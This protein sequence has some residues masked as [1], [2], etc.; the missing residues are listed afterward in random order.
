MDP[1]SQLEPAREQVLAAIGEVV[2]STRFI[3][4]PVVQE[5]EQTLAA[6][7]GAT[8]GVGVGNGTDALVIAL[9]ALG[10]EPG[11]EV[12]CPSFT[13]YATAEAV[14]GIGAVPVFADIDPGT[15][16]LNPQPAGPALPRPRK[17][18]LGSAS[19]APPSTPPPLEASAPPPG[20]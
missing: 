12:I 14:A 20:S 1:K 5:A 19:S 9:R 17:P 2:E 8:R 7:V 6:Y 4:G 15:Y 16:C 10:V 18:G 3:L 13:F 11:D